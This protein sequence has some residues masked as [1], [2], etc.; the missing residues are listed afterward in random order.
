LERRG[1][2]E[3]IGGDRDKYFFRNE[4]EREKRGR[5]V[6]SKREEEIHPT[7]KI[8]SGGPQRESGRRRKGTPDLLFSL[9]MKTYS[10]KERD[11]SAGFWRGGGGGP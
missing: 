5:E 7:R 8:K 10:K 11:W 3:G 1:S 4:D 9:K 6:G 2:P